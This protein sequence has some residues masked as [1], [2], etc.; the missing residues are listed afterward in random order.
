[1]IG[2]GHSWAQIQEYDFDQ[3]SLFYKTI[4]Q[5]ESQQ[6]AA[7]ITTTRLGAWGDAKQVTKVVKQLS[8][9]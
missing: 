5:Q 7:Q 1:M 3:L 8:G 4:K 9:S 2:A 6:Q